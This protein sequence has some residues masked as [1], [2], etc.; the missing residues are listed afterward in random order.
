MGL[1]MMRSTIFVSDIADEDSEL[2]GV[3]VEA[4]TDRAE[5]GIEDHP[6][7]VSFTNR[8]HRLFIYLGMSQAR[9]L[10][11]KLQAAVAEAESRL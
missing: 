4:E 9:G 1:L 11:E 7:T 10:L 6:I 2:L 5:Y 3:A 8:E